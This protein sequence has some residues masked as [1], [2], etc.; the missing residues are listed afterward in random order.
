MGASSYVLVGQKAAL[1][2]T[3]GSACHGAGRALSRAKAK[4]EVNAEAL[5]RE[6]ARQGI[7]VKGASN[8]GIVEEAPDAYK[9]V[10]RVVNVVH[11]AGIARK[12]VRL[13]PLGVIK[14]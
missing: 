14:G 9:D 1:A 4:R 11:N 13:R 8:A 12:V 5:V 7:R 2:L 6:L 10:T 3:F